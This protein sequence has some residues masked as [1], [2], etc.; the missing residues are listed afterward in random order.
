MIQRI[1]SLFLVIV[2]ALTVTMICTKMYTD[3]ST[4]DPYEAGWISDLTSAIVLVVVAAVSLVTI[5]LF[6][7]RML[8]IRL[9]TLCSLAMLGEQIYIAVRFFT[10]PDT[11]V[12]AISAIFPLLCFILLT[13]SAR[14]IAKDHAL[15]LSASRLR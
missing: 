6:K 5:F 11:I 14:A 13:L 12:Y 4:P 15:V 7:K 2:F 8:H 3:F 10:R 9:C 1:Q